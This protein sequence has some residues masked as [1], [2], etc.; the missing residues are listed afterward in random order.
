MNKERLYYLDFI[1]TIA[2]IAILLTHFNAVFI[3]SYPMEVWDRMV[4]TY[5][6]CNL[7]IG[8][9]GV[10][11]FFVVSGA[12]LMYVYDEKL[13]LKSFFKKRFLAIYPMFWIAYVVAFFYLFY[14]NKGINMAIPKRNFIFTFLGF[15]GYLN[16]VVPNFYILGEWFLGC[17]IL[18][19]AVFPLLR[20]GVNNHPV[21]C[22]I[23][24]LALYVLSVWL[25]NGP[26]NRVE[27]ITTRM[28]EILFGMYFVKYIK[29]VNVPLFIVSLIILIIN[30]YFAPDWIASFQT[31]YIGIASFC[32]LVFIYKFIDWKIIRKICA[33]IS[34]YSYA[35]FLVHHVIIDRITSTFDLA[36]LSRTESYLLFIT[37]CLI[38][39]VFA[40]LLYVANDICIEKFT[41]SRA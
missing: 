12:A 20:W 41:K 1:R 40:K 25:Y 28:P 13:E 31:T 36:L 15:D 10:A 30:T 7:Y 27:L 26:I 19:Y 8:D 34:K 38:T 11:L 14:I 39:A 29:K 17:I 22:G 4:L 33:C 5:K 32:V 24:V 21:I 2:V 6:V 23:V 9:F 35:I 37:C 3:I 16:G 18:I